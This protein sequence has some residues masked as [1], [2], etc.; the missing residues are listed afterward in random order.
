M[1]LNILFL[2]LTIIKVRFTQKCSRKIQK[3]SDIIHAVLKSPKKNEILLE[4]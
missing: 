1:A 4:L 3:C 2:I